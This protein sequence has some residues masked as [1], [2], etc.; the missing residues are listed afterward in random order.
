MKVE[1]P[2]PVFRRDQGVE[3]KRVRGQRCWMGHGGRQ[4]EGHL[5]R[6][7]RRDEE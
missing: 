5:G 6:E 7:R 1:R 3:V 4:M 2:Q